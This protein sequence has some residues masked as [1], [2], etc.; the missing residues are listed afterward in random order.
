MLVSKQP[1]T[2][3][4]R[5]QD[6]EVELAKA[7]I[8]KDDSVL[9]V[10]IVADPKEGNEKEQIDLIVLASAVMMH[11]FISILGVEFNIF[12]KFL[13]LLIYVQI[14]QLLSVFTLFGLLEGLSFA[15]IKLRLEATE[16]S[17]CGSGRK[18]LHREAMNGLEAA[19]VKFT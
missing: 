11:D 12:K 19:I 16:E 18:W 13:L 6:A 9:F 1:E 15:S 17:D 10:V 3:Y 5:A 4:A 7:L 2:K 8:P 14:W